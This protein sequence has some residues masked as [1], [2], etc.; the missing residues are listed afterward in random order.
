M[1]YTRNWSIPHL[2]ISFLGKVYPKEMFGDCDDIVA[3]VNESTIFSQAAF[4][5][6][7]EDMSEDERSV[8]KKTLAKDGIT[9]DPEVHLCSEERKAELEKSYWEAFQKSNY[10]TMQAPIRIQFSI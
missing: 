1:T 10:A 5:K 9:I 2:D 7:T 8:M 3:S 6:A 4:L